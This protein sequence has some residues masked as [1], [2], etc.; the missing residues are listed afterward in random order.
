M[1]GTKTPQEEAS[2][3]PVNVRHVSCKI[4][5]SAEPSQIY[6]ALAHPGSLPHLSEIQSY[7]DLFETKVN[8]H[9]VELQTHS[10]IVHKWRLNNWPQNHYSQ[11]CISLVSESSPGTHLSLSHTEI[12]SSHYE[13]TLLEW[14]KFWS[15]F[16]NLFGYTYTSFQW[17]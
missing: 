14:E 11:V 3:V 5:F 2:A 4:F 9:Q 16:S 15:T 7:F 13:N 17:S 12:P 8:G 1:K 10:K 6:Q